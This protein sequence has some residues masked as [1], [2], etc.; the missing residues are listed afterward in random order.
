M[1][2]SNQIE[3]E[4]DR[5]PGY[6]NISLSAVAAECA[7]NCLLPFI[8]LNTEKYATRTGAQ[9]PSKYIV[10]ASVLGFN[11]I[12][13]YLQGRSKRENDRLTGFSNGFLSVLTSFPDVG[14]SASDIVGTTSSYHLGGFYCFA[15]MIVSA[16][17]YARG[18]LDSQLST[19]NFIN[20]TRWKTNCTFVI[21]ISIVVCSVFPSVPTD[22]SR[23]DIVPPISSIVG[24]IIAT[25]MSA[26]GAVMGTIVVEQC[27]QHDLWARL[28]NNLAS[29]VF[30]LWT[31]IRATQ[32]GHLSFLML[33]FMTAYCGA[34]SNYSGT[35]GDIMEEYRKQNLRSAVSNFSIHFVMCIALMIL[36]LHLVASDEAEIPLGESIIIPA[37]KVQYLDD[38][39]YKSH[40]HQLV[41]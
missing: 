41:L 21:I 3:K 27:P 9:P 4:K 37:D 20:P 13:S 30:V 22:F 8:V 32:S 14:E 36:A 15:G 38:F 39:S 12:G 35:I 24:L 1:N 19:E 28:I 5:S 34:L 33:K 17:L 31:R 16:L 7:M 25:G 11:F 26:T 2:D 10:A 23:P 40:R 18:C 29:C 6:L